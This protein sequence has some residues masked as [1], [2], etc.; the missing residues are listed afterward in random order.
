[1]SAMGLYSV[2]PWEPS[3][4]FVRNDTCLNTN[5]YKENSPD[6]RH[7]VP[8]FGLG[9]AR[10]RD[11]IKNNKEYLKCSFNMNENYES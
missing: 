2:R 11:E 6:N 4:E 8:T 3:H 9:M 5:I 1:M 7:T 10:G